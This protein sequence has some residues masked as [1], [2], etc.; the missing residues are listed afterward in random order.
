[1]TLPRATEHVSVIVV[2]NSKPNVSPKS[3]FGHT[4]GYTASNGMAIYSS[5]NEVHEHR[6]PMKSSKL[7]TKIPVAT[8]FFEAS[9]YNISGNVH[10]SSEQLFGLT[11]Q[12]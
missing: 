8:I 7:N 12:L 6:S 1:M 11:T 2:L 9:S 3:F 4:I 10:N 5:V